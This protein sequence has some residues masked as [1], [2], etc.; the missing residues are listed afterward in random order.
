[1][2]WIS[3]DPA[4]LT[5][6]VQWD[7]A[8]MLSVATLRPPSKAERRER[9]L[10][11]PAVAMDV[12]VAGSSARVVVFYYDEITAWLW[13]LAGAQAVVAE[14][15]FGPSKTTIKQH[16]FR[17][18]YVAALCA[19]RGIAFHEV[20]VSEWRKVVG[21]ANGF[22]FPRDTDGAKARAMELIEKRFGSA[23]SDDEADAGCAGLWAL[24]TRTV[25][26]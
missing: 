24:Q 19:Q 11:K 21:E 13:L 10:A 6:I 1:M 2:R 20:N 3:L 18:G 7:G 5:G 17:R 16:A 22:T 14:E 8:R 15:G 23:M 12:L 9:Q 25:Q 26:P 4:A